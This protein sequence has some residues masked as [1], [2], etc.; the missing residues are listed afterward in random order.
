AINFYYRSEFILRLVT[1]VRKIKTIKKI[2]KIYLS[3]FFFFFFSNCLQKLAEDYKL[4]HIL[5]D[6]ILYMQSRS[7]IFFKNFLQVA[8]FSVTAGDETQ[9]IDEITFIIISFYYSE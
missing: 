2:N 9:M 5:H 4:I 8:R 1:Y 3:L 7:T 6:Y